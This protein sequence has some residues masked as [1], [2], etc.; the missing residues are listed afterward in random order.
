MDLSIIYTC[1]LGHQRVQHYLQ[2]KMTLGY[3]IPVELE[4]VQLNNV[5]T[6]IRLEE[7]KVEKMKLPLLPLICQT[8]S[9]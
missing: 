8:V 9:V 6:V 4:T 3:V 7:L 2:Q 1:P 5:K